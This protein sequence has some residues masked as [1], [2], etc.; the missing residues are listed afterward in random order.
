MLKG[1][2]FLIIL[3]VTFDIKSLI[4]DISLESLGENPCLKK[5]SIAKLIQIKK[6]FN[7]CDM[8]RIRNPKIKRFT[9]R[10]QHIS[11]F[12]QRRLDYFFVSNLPQD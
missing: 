11:G 1:A 5:K 2:H 4:F 3:Q 8:W 12:I 9:F 6:K 7:L 10:Q